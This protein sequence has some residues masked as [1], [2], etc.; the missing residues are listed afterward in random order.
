MVFSLKPPPPQSFTN[1]SLQMPNFEELFS[2][3]FGKNG[4]NVLIDFQFKSSLTEDK[5]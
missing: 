2:F 5:S 3:S 4:E 1:V